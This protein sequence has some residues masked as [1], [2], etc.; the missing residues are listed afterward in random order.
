MA[1]SYRKLRELLHDKKIKRYKLQKDLN[2]SS[3]TTAKI[4]KDEYMSMEILEKIVLYLECNGF[5]DIV[6]IKK[7]TLL[8]ILKF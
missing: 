6:E 5:D 3:A 7:D 4:D 8:S 2:L 1:I